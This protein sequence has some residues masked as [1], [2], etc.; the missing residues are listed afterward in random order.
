VAINQPVITASLDAEGNL[1]LL[2]YLP[3]DAPAA[4]AG[5]EAP[6]ASGTSPVASRPWDVEVGAVTVAGAAVDLTSRVQVREPIVLRIAPLDVSVGPIALPAKA[7]LPVRASA[8]IEPSGKLTLAGGHDLATGVTTLDV[9][10]SGLELPV[11]QPV[12]DTQTQVALLKG[13]AGARGRLVAGGPD[14]VHYTGVATVDALRIADRLNGTDLLRW[15]R[16]TASGIDLR[17]EPLKA[18][19]RDLLLQ[20][21]YAQ[22]V[23]EP[24][25]TT[26]IGVAFAAPGTVPPADQPLPESADAGEEDEADGP[27]AT[28]RSAQAPAS[29]AG[30]GTPKDTASDAPPSPPGSAGEALPFDIR[31]VRIANGSMQFTDRTLTPQFSTGILAMNGSIT[32]LSGRPGSVAEVSIDGSV[33]QY[34]PVTIRGNVNYF[35][36]TSLTDLQMKFSNI[37]MTTFSPYSGKFAGYRIEKG[38]LNLETNYRIVDSKLDARHHIVIDQLQLGDKVESKEAVSLPLKLAVALLKDRN[39]VID[40]DIPVTGSLDDPKFRVGPIIWKMVKNLLVKVATAPFAFIGGL[41]GGGEEMQYIE[42]APGRSTIDAAGLEKL[43][44][45]RKALVDRPGLSVDI[46]MVHDA[47]RDA[48]ALVDAKWDAMLDAAAVT[49]FGEKAQEPGFV[50]GLA[51]VPKDRRKLMVTAYRTQF[52]KDPQWPKP[53]KSDPAQKDRDPDELAAEWVEQQLRPAVTA[54]E[55]DLGALGKAR[56][57]AIQDALLRDGGIEPSRVFVIAQQNAPPA[58]GAAAATGTAAAPVR[59]QLSLK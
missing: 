1:N 11:L 34:A 3:P 51:A 41:F 9:D 17:L 15:R 50:D 23:I 58:S 12:F 19:V 47:A 18:S 49:R 7:P 25:G 10:A 36:A 16:L 22:L 54:G 52:G 46:P 48:P 13:S 27:V 45:L 39:G 8:T 30:S 29:P 4:P 31:Q 33:D 28:V 40:L 57:E 24:N 44:N 26:N 2:A 42:F 37:E 56:A 38:K 6:L 55:G 5:G 35:A 53:D 21:P 14:V 43:A 20:E 32:G 59:V